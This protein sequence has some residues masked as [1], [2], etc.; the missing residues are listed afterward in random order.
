MGGAVPFLLLP[1]T[2]PCSRLRISFSC[3]ARKYNFVK[4]ALE[5]I[6]FFSYKHISGIKHY[7]HSVQRDTLF[8]MLKSEIIPRSKNTVPCWASGLY[9]FILRL[10]LGSRLK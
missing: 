3:L 9:P 10:F 2:T 4:S 5:S 1:N 7:D 6:R 8:K